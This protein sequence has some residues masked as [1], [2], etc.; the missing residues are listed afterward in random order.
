MLL[1]TA[2]VHGTLI[3]PGSIV[4]TLGSVVSPGLCGN[5]SLTD[6]NGTTLASGGGAFGAQQTSTFCLN[7]GGAPFWQ[8]DNDNAHAKQQQSFAGLRIYPTL[9]KDDLFV[10]LTEISQGQI[11]IINMNGQILQRYEQIAPQMH[12]S[13]GD[14]PA[15]IYFV[16][17]VAG[18]TVW[19]E[20]FV[21]K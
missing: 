18:D 17:M 20:K 7:G 3:A 5:Y 15:G 10:E 14:L 4:A 8:Q 13:V 9:T 21:K 12:L 1:T 11:N 2:C 6:I 16:Q 19:V